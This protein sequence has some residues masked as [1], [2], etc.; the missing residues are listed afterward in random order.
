MKDIIE[1]LNAKTL[2]EKLTGL[3]QFKF[4]IPIEKIFEIKTKPENSDLSF[5]A[6]NSGKSPILIAEKTKLET[7]ATKGLFGAK[8]LLA[9][10][11]TKKEAFKNPFAKKPEN[12]NPVFAFSLEEKKK[13]KN[14]ESNLSYFS[15][16]K[17]QEN[18]FP[19]AKSRLED[20]DLNEANGADAFSAKKICFP[21]CSVDNKG[22][23]CEAFVA[24]NFTPKANLLL[25]FENKN[26]L[27]NMKF[28]KINNFIDNNEKHTNN[29]ISNLN[30]IHSNE[31][32]N[33][34]LFFFANNKNDNIKK[35]NDNKSLEQNCDYSAMS[36]D[37]HK[38]Q[39][40]SFASASKP[41]PNPFKEKIKLLFNKRNSDLQTS[42]NLAPKAFE[43]VQRL[44]PENPS[45]P[46]S[47]QIEDKNS[48]FSVNSKDSTEDDAS[49]IDNCGLAAEDKSAFN[50]LF[51][52]TFKYNRLL[53]QSIKME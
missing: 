8:P 21:G 26:N 9:C 12:K 36:A 19:E 28:N 5:P 2:Q 13:K 17:E 10:S 14:E 27:L 30:I 18:E 37:K 20:L 44:N 39:T 23:N 7:H 11:Q 6:Q 41:I 47:S 33:V 38:T 46:S 29:S 16:L 4:E 1:S 43:R 34:N 40:L 45:A 35:N 42:R 48:A 31:R 24:Q 49:S 22:F 32:K 50:S 53:L 52:D 51:S 25:A 3:S 15:S